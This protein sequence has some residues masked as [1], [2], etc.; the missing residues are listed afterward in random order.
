M[1]ELLPLLLLLPIAV[2]LW[3]PACACQTCT[4]LET[5]MPLDDS[6]KVL[7]ADMGWRHCLLSFL[8]LQAWRRS[9]SRDQTVAWCRLSTS[10]VS[11][12]LL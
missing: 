1:L 8:L 2:A 5:R 12:A 4:F 10:S 7:P 3:R 9:R 11:T 6:N